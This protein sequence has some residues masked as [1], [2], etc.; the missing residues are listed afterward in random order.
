MRGP[1]EF[2]FVELV[3]HRVGKDRDGVFFIHELITESL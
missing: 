1:T 3:L 2:T